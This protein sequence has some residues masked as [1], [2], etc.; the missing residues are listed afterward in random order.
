MVAVVAWL[1]SSGMVEV[2]AWLRLWHGCGCGMVAVVAWLRSSGMV[3]VVAWLRLW[4]GCGCGMVAVL[5]WLRLLITV[6]S[7]YRLCSRI[8]KL[9]NPQNKL[10]IL[11]LN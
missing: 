11:Y 3:E 6:T 2:V 10:G 4:H 1:R 9:E 5:T 7:K 8:S